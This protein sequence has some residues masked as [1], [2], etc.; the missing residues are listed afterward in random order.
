[1]YTSPMETMHLSL[2]VQA[3]V[4][5]F[6]WNPTINS[7]WIP[8]LPSPHNIYDHNLYLPY[9]HSIRPN[10][11][12]AGLWRL[13]RLVCKAYIYDIWINECIATLFAWKWSKSAKWLENNSHKK[14][15]IRL[16]ICTNVNKYLVNIF[17]T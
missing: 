17:L 16:K 9:S 10:L 6:S 4:G 14:I 15:N 8:V 5:T 11:Y 7:T 2:R 12:T 1:M 13:C 3:A